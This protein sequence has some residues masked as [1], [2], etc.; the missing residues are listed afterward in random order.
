I[1]PEKILPSPDVVLLVSDDG[2][3]A[4]VF[5]YTALGDFAGDTLHPSVDDA[6]QE[7]EAEYLEALLPWEAVPDHVGDPHAFAVRYA[8]ERL[9]DR[10][11][12][13]D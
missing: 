1:E 10:G 13:Y 2:T 5:R 12:G 9:N 4:M 6:Q 3:S 7:T 8:H 11:D